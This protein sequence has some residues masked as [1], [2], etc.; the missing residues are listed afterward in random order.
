MLDV[1]VIG[2]GNVGSLLSTYLLNSSH[3]M[4]L[5][6]METNLDAEGGLLDLKHSMLL[7][8][9]KELYINNEEQFLNANF[10]FQSAGFANGYFSKL[11]YRIY[12]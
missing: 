5:N 2:F 10:V 4:K 3:A 9:S 8:P 11:N 7:Y 12:S 1:T 6:I